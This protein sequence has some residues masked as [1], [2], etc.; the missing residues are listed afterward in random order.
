MSE[1]DQKPEQQETELG[2]EELEK[3]N[4]GAK[5]S[6][7]DALTIKQTVVRDSVSADDLGKK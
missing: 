1:Q 4:G 3:V 7:V 6:K 2:P 5:V